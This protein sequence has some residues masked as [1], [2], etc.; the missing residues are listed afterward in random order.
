[1][2]STVLTK[3]PTAVE[4]AR[5]GGGW[6]FAGQHQAGV[7]CS[8]AIDGVRDAD[9]E[10]V[11]AADTAADDIAF[12]CR[13]PDAGDCAGAGHLTQH[14]A[15]ISGAHRSGGDH[16]A[17]AG[18]SHRRGAGASAVRQR[19]CAGWSPPLRRTGLG[20]GHAGAEAAGRHPDDPVGGISRRSS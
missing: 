9:Q 17:T 12:R 15:R 3:P 2:P 5:P 19:R 16:V 18:R 1:M 14:G 4:R 6:R 11:H 7:Q 13:C 20:S 10:A 8:I